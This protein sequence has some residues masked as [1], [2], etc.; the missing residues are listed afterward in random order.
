M[1]AS[2]AESRGR[3]EEGPMQRC[4]NADTAEQ[5]QAHAFDTAYPENL[6]GQAML[7]YSLLLELLK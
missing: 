2:A 1:T 5:S 6:A 7:T 3:L 4:G